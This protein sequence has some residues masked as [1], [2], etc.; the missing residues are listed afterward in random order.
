MELNSTT[1]HP[2]EYSKYVRP[3]EE[4]GQFHQA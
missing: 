1:Q 2:Y 3:I 4:G